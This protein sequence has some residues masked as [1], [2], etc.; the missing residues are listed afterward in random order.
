[1][2]AIVEVTT[3]MKRCARQG[4]TLAAKR[5]KLEK[6][7]TT[8]GKPFVR[9]I[10]AMMFVLALLL[11]SAGCSPTKT[12]VRESKPCPEA[13]LPID[14]PAVS[15]QINVVKDKAPR[16][17]LD[18]GVLEVVLQPNIDVSKLVLEISGAGAVKLHTGKNMKSLPPGSSFLPSVPIRDR[19]Q[20]GVEALKARERQ[21]LTFPFQILED[22]YGYIM[23]KTLGPEGEATESTSTMILDVLSLNN[24]V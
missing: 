10:L 12:M 15:L 7:V 9:W 16:K 19:V 4:G 1:M 24:R 6:P 22:G 3:F 8:L 18:Q 17:T 14:L 5:P 21:V 2:Y 20:M 23:I 13:Q 11:P